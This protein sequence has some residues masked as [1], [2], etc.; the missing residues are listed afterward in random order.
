MNIAIA[1][2]DREGKSSY[3]YFLSRG[4][5]LTILDQNEKTEVPEGALAVLGANYLDNLDR[6]DLIL[7]T[8]GLPPRVI[9]AANPNLNS[10][11]ITTQVNEFFKACP[12]K[13]IIGVTGTKGKGT[14]STLIY[15][16]LTETGQDTHLAGN[17]GLPALEILPKLTADSWV[18]LELSSFQLIDFTGA[19]QVAVCLMVVPE[20]LNWHTDMAE[21]IEAKTQL[22]KHQT[23][24]QVAIY[25]PKNELSVAVSSVGYATK[26]PYLEAPGAFVEGDAVVIDGTFICNT[27]EL[28]LLGTHNWQNVCAAVTAAWQATQN[29]VAI[30]NV[31][32]SFTGLKH[33]LEL[34]RT[35]NDVSYYDD[36]F[37]TTP[38]TAIV[39]VAAL[40]QPKILILGGSD[41][42]ASY[43]VLAT[44]VKL[45]EVRNVI[46]IGEQAPRIRAALQKAGYTDFVL[47]GQTMSNIVF[48]AQSLAQPGDAVI[49]STACASFDM[50]E[51]YEDRGD[52]FK[53]AVQALA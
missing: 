24:G 26:L 30:R 19:P 46:L 53:S 52:Q 11:K 8:A 17:I 23:V 9:F 4:N 20:H 14:T 15:R 47:G 40:P 6:F 28:K 33:R 49:L 32:T 31:L 21:Y 42:G 10:A 27:S 5:S 2:F 44:A 50:F 37:G 12:T 39:A 41:K 38:E 36:S 22:F 16:M 45:G 35:H 7:R 51:N 29:K 25:F 34:V 1:G 3:Q 18:V 13:N 48:S 43:G